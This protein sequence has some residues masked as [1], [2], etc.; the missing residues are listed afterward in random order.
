MLKDLKE[1]QKPQKTERPG[2]EIKIKDEFCENK[3]TSAKLGTLDNKNCPETVYLLLSFWVDIKTEKDNV[4]NYD[5]IISK[6]FE[7]E[8]KKIYN[9]NLYEVLNKNKYFPYPFENIYVYDFPSNL[10]YNEKKSFVSIE[11]NLHTINCDKKNNYPLKNDK[12]NELFNELIKIYNIIENSDLLL[13]K[14]GFNI[15]KSKK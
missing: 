7:R 6:K 9:K 11:L 2:K 12:Q 15:Y 1:L 13:G 5:Y 8:L 3:N 14:S 4:E 10:N